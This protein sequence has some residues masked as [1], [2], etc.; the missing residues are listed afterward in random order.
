[1]VSV[2]GVLR[3]ANANIN[4]DLF[5][6]LRGGGPSSFGVV[7]EATYKTFA[8][9]PSTA[10][11]LDINTGHTTNATLL[12]EAIRVFHGYSTRF[13]D[14]GLYVYY[15]ILGPL[16]RVHPIVGIGKTAAQ[17][18]GIVKPMFDALDALGVGYDTASSAYPTFYDLYDA[19]FEPEVAGNSALTGGWTI[20]R[21][22]AQENGAGLVDAFRN[23]I[24][25]GSII[26]GHMWNAG[27][28]LPS[29][30]W[31]KSA[32]NPR[33][34]SVVD[35][36]ITVLPIAGNASLAAKAAAQNTLTNVIDGG[37]RAAAPNGA[38]YVN[39]ADPFQPN[40]QTAFW[41]TNYPALLR[42]RSRWDPEGVLYAVSTPGT[43]K[44]EQIEWGTRLCK[45]L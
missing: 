17:L 44:W 22:D 11:T 19:V 39:E 21:K 6:A 1:M 45:K 8:D 26:V 5:W 41:G 36:V 27:G 37:I 14:N 3:T 12:W 15:E 33:F 28:G 34:R 32:V 29:S 24:N 9:L 20:G 18:A 43:E 31:S 4:A 7:V 23:A 13:V 2:D 42:A 10:I 25:N 40:W 35:K 30:Q 16:L 38:A